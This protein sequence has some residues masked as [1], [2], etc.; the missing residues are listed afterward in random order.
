M[1]INTLSKLT[2]PDY[3]KFSALLIDIF[4]DVEITDIKYEKLQ[5]AVN[6]VL[7]E[8]GLEQVEVQQ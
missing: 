2:Y 1:R 3:V 6:K 7:I 4:P 8:M 5:E